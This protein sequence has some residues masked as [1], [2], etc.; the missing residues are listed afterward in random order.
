M[1]SHFKVVQIDE[2]EFSIGAMLTPEFAEGLGDAMLD[3]P[4]SA[5]RALG[6]SLKRGAIELQL[7]E[8]KIPSLEKH[9]TFKAKT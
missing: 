8:K 4:N 6:S 7:R 3:S 9:S 1:K 2:Q 5:F